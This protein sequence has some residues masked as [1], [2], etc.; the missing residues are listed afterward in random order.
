L[1]DTHPAIAAIE[2]LRV[3]LDVEKLSYDQAWSVVT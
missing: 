2:L 3:L 1:N